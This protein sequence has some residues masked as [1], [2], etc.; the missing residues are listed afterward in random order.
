[1]CVSVTRSVIVSNGL[2]LLDGEGDS[3]VKAS[4]EDLILHGLI[5][6]LPFLPFADL[7]LHFW[8]HICP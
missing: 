4:V 7:L 6:H 2:L 5:F 3:Q 1:M 8:T